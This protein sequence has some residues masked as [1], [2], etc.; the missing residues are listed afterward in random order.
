MQF[1]ATFPVEFRRAQWDP[2][3]RSTAG[4]VVL[5]QIWPIIGRRGV[6]AHHYDPTGIALAAQ[7]L[8]SAAARSAPT[9]N[10]DR[11]RCT[12][13]RKRR[14][15]WRWLAFL[16]NKDHATLSLDAPAADRIKRRWPSR[17][18]GAQAETGVMPRAPNSILDQEAVAQ[19]PAI[20]RAH[21]ADRE[22]LLATSCQQD[23][24]GPNMAKQ[25]GAICELRKIKAVG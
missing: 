19:R 22:D 13:D 6:G 3:L 12:G 10:D 25:H 17:L 15:N 8:G 18:A 9:Q 14:R 2:F 16:A 4:Q 5:R 7:R 24:L 1:D 11:P 20:M 23:G 21:S